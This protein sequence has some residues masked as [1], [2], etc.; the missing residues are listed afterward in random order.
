MTLIIDSSVAIK[1]FVQENQRDH[2]LQILESRKD[3]LAPDF[4]EIEMANI[5]WKKVRQNEIDGSHVKTIVAALPE[6]IPELLPTSPFIYRAIE[7]A[8]DLDHPIYDC[9]YLACAMHQNGL[10]VTA[11]KRLFNKLQPTAYKDLV[12]FLDDPSLISPPPNDLLR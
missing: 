11:D 6:Y 2:A 1:W 3:I 9:V 5:T 12:K 10:I 4:I 8:I 7:L